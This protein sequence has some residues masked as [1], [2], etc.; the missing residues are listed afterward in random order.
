MKPVRTLL[1]LASEAEARLLLNDGP[2]KGLAEVAGLRADD[3]PDTAQ[4]FTDD[5]GRQT[6]APGMGHHAYQAR[7][8]VR[9]ARRTTFAGLI[10]EAME[11]AWA[12][13]RYDRV[14][15]AASPKLLGELR[16]RMPGP[17][18]DAVAADLPKDLVKVAARDLPSH[19]GDVAA[20]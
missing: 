12:T 15:L 20:F 10:V 3:F 16:A 17:L 8:T 18:A 11:E 9:D 2:G 1:V 5:A 7:E 6:G 4:E 19:F 13:G 14:V